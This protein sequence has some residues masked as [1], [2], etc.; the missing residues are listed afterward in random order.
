MQRGA[1]VAG[2]HPQP[3]VVRRRRVQPHQHPVGRGLIAGSI[4]VARRV[5]PRPQQLRPGTAFIRLDGRRARQPFRLTQAPVQRLAQVA[6]V[7]HQRRRDVRM[8]LPRQLA[9]RLPRFARRAAA[10]QALVHRVARR[11]RIR[12]RRHRPLV[13]GLRH[14][15]EAGAVAPDAQRHPGRLVAQ[16]GAEEQVVRRHRVKLPA[17]PLLRA[18]DGVL[19]A[20]QAAHLALRQQVGA[21]LQ[22]HRHLTAA[23]RRRS[24]ALD[25]IALAVR[26]HFHRVA[27]TRLEADVA[28]HVQSADRVARRHGAAAAGSQ[29]T[30]RAAAADNTAA[31]HADGRGD[32][33]VDCQPPLIDQRRAGIGVGA[34]HDQ[35]AHPFFGQAAVARDV[36]GVDFQFAADVVTLSGVQR[37]GIHLGAQARNIGDKLGRAVGHARR[38]RDAELRR[39]I[40]DGIE[41][42]RAVNGFAQ[43]DHPPAVERVDARRAHVGGGSFQHVGNLRRTHVRETLQQHRHRAGDVRRRHRGAVFIAVVRHQVGR[44]GTVGHSAVDFAARRRDAEAGGIAAAGREAADGVRHAV[45]RCRILRHAGDRQPV[46]RDVRHEVGQPAD[47]IR[48]VVVA[49]VTGGEQ[50]QNIFARGVDG[51]LIA[52]AGQAAEQRFDLIEL[53]LRILQLKVQRV[54]IAAAVGQKVGN[55]DAPAV[56]DHPHAV[57]DHRLPAG[58]GDGAVQAEEFTIGRAVVV[59]IDA[60]HLRIESHAVHADAV[61]VGGADARN[62]H[63]MIAQHAL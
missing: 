48:L 44:I 59:V 42:A 5:V 19:L 57:V 4:G 36:V 23:D 31:L 56:V 9:E 63:P 30:H 53:F 10:E 61:A 24:A 37:A 32:R 11:Q 3:P 7:V 6:A 51:A 12:R 43:V 50:H 13:R 22:R 46:W 16:P 26:P 58:I 20:Q 2:R 28:S 38:I 54:R 41:H 45:G 55:T 1:G 27:R 14:A 15:G 60:D 47:H 18:Q 33:A 39:N 52:C 21:V 62:V 29:R 40:L 49:V 8:D 34:G 25:P 17:H 35:R